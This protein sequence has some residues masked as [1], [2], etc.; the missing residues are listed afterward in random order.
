MGVFH[1]DKRMNDP[2]VYVHAHEGEVCAATLTIDE[3]TFY[4][5]REMDTDRQLEMIAHVG[6]RIQVAVAR[7]RLNMEGAA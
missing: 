1:I 3:I 2:D 7:A 4:T 6:D 5:P